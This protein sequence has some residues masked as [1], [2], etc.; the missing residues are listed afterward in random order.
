MV[1]DLKV[2]LMNK[3]YLMGVEFN[4]LAKEPCMRGIIKMARKIEKA[5]LFIKAVT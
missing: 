5:V 2:K 1:A 4:S 3:A